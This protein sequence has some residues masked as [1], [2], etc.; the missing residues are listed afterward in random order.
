MTHEILPRVVDVTSSDASSDDIGRMKYRLALL[1]EFCM[2]Y[3]FCIYSYVSNV[4][5]VG[6]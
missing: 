2:L 3:I 1:S 5:V 6:H 4:Y